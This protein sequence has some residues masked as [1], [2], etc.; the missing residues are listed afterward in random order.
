MT[1]RV[2]VGRALLDAAEYRESFAEC[3]PHDST[4]R[5]EAFE[6]A[7]MYREE[8]A[9]R[10]FAERV[11]TGKAVSIFEIAKGSSS[12]TGRKEK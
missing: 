10:G 8:A 6:L 9:R 5:Q 2:L 11:P 1:K 7:R 12:S 4:V 3:Q